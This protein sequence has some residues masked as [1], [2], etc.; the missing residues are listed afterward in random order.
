MKISTSALL[1]L[2]LACTAPPP[3]P[4]DDVA[5][6]RLARPSAERLHADVAWL[7]DDAQE[8]RRAGTEAGRRCA[9]WLAERFAALGLEPAGEDGGWFQSFE[10][11]LPIA[12]GG[13]STVEWVED[14]TRASIRGEAAV[15]PLFCS[16]GAS[17]SGRLAW[18]GF[19]IVDEQRGR[20]DYGGERV[21]G[22]VVIVVRGAP[23]APEAAA[24]EGAEGPE[25]DGA[26]G[27][28]V[29]EG[30]GWGNSATIFTKVMNA[31]R[32]GA[33]AVIVA[34]HPDAGGEPLHFDPSRSAQANVPALYLTAWAAE[35]LVPHFA[36]RVRAAEAGTGETWD[37]EQVDVTADVRREKGE[38]LNVLARLPGNGAG[39]TIVVGAHYDHLGHGGEG[40][41]D[42]GGDA[43]HNGADDNASGTAAVLELARLWSAAPTPPAGDL[44]FAL[45]SGEEEGLLGSEHWAQH[46]TV[47][48][49]QVAANL[50]LDMVG[51][52]GDQVLTVLG[53]G[54][55]APFAELLGD[56]AVDAGLDLKVNRSG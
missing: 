30:A 40:S 13:A 19:G 47:P 15:L 14:G 50:N 44:I 52:A 45:W 2:A 1:L 24:A 33:A 29:E 22:R 48:L 4:C 41:L 18:R 17:A 9:R 51:R 11:P 39:R 5:V 38:A 46:P 7:A 43:I 55:A 16:D 53:A 26:H 42:T 49:A 20:D 10:V 35:R 37:G 36:E 23:P 27:G 32:R 6:E 8:G 28:L 56:A 31:K 21:D 12:D 54:T 3:A 25:G 34:E